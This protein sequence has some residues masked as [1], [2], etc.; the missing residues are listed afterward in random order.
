MSQTYLGLSTTLFFLFWARLWGCHRKVVA[1]WTLA[2]RFVLFLQWE[3]PTI[4]AGSFTQTLF[5]AK[6]ALHM[7]SGA[8]GC[9][10]E[11]TKTSQK[12]RKTSQK[13]AKF[14]HRH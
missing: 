8:Q 5:D 2:V 6:T 13:L 1:I 7:P 11:K 9:Q 12:I 14:F 10:V 3:T 4:L